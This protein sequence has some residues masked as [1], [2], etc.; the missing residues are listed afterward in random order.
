MTDPNLRP[1]VRGL[2]IDPSDRVLLV[3][4]EVERTGWIGWILPGGGI[5]AGEDPIA[6]LKRELHEETGLEDAFVGPVVCHRRQLG[7]RIAP[8]FDGQ[9]EAIH[10]VP[11]RPFEPA[12]ALDDDELHAEGIRG[13]RWWTLDELRATEDVVVPEDFAALVERVLEFGGS[14][15]PLVIEVT[16]GE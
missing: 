13:M 3:H 8:G 12:G 15:E 1:A 14:V 7:P 9:E 4:F 10:L 16:E 5:E 6:A 2:L 11:C